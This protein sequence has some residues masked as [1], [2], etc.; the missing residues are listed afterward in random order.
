[1]LQQPYYVISIFYDKDFCIIKKSTKLR[2]RALKILIPSD[3][4]LCLRGK[5]T[6]TLLNSLNWKKEINPRSDLDKEISLEIL[7]RYSL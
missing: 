2:T 1:M 7:S 4:L 6:S 3:S 5:Q